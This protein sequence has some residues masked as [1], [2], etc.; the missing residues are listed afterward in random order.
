MLVTLI[1]L[2]ALTPN[3]DD[4]QYGEFLSPLVGACP[5]DARKKRKGAKTK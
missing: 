1:V 3:V 2:Y 5:E 4:A